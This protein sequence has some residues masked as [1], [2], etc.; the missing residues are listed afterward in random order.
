MLQREDC[1]ATSIPSKALFFSLI[2]SSTTV[3]PGKQVPPFSLIQPDFGLLSLLT[4]LRV[5]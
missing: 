1:K 5:S 3:D 4:L 2:P